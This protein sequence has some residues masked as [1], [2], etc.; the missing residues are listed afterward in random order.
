VEGERAGERTK[1]TA[2][3]KESQDASQGHSNQT[4]AGITDLEM[5]VSYMIENP[6]ETSL[7]EVFH[8][9]LSKFG[10]SLDTTI[11]DRYTLRT[12]QRETR[13]TARVSLCSKVA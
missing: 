9:F 12:C 3:S 2:K 7:S 13:S 11:N 4:L 5:L 1:N 6:C 8:P 10:G